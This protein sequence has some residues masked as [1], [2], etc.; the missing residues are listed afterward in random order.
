MDL[1]RKTIEKIRKSPLKWQIDLYKFNNY[2]REQLVEPL[3]DVLENVVAPLLAADQKMM[4]H[5]YMGEV[6]YNE[7]VG[8][9]STEGWRS[10]PLSYDSFND[11]IDNIREH[12]FKYDM[13]EI[14]Y[15]SSSTN[16]VSILS[17]IDRIGFEVLKIIEKT[18]HESKT[19]VNRPNLY[20]DDYAAFFPYWNLSEGII[21]LSRYQILDKVNITYNNRIHRIPC[22]FYALEQLVNDGVI[23]KDVAIK[24]AMKC[25]SAFTRDWTNN[26]YNST[27]LKKL[28]NMFHIYSKI[29]YIKDN[30]IYN[31]IKTKD[32]GVPKNEARYQIELGYYKLLIVFRV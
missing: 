23:E 31:E 14:N 17:V 32:V 19:G 12:G 30:N 21:D 20:S 3:V 22:V 11:L 26:F 18:Y 9:C 15:D 27:D 28:C 8:K 4:L 6:I 24:V 10:K 13:E 2:G 1:V 5:Y 25:H 16:I 29:H 7:N